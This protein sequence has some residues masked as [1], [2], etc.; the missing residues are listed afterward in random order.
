[1]YST[2]FSMCCTTQGAQENWANVYICTCVVVEYS[3]RM[4]DPGSLVHGNYSQPPQNFE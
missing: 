4:L 1:M 3:T 2:S